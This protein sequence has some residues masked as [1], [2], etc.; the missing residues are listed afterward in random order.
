MFLLKMT[1]Q[2][3]INSVLVWKKQ[4]VFCQNCCWSRPISK[5]LWWCSVLFEI[6]DHKLAIFRCVYNICVFSSTIIANVFKLLSD[7][8]VAVGN[9]SHVTSVLYI[10]EGVVCLQRMMCLSLMNIS[11]LLENNW[12]PK[13]FSSILLKHEQNWCRIYSTRYIYCIAYKTTYGKPKISAMYMNWYFTQIALY[14]YC[15]KTNDTSL[16]VFWFSFNYLI[17]VAVR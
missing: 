3:L 17:H 4:Y 15:L 13:A 8:S 9:W 1:A 2:I 16:H 10:S 12:N 7:M 6:H 5:T 14:F 11:H